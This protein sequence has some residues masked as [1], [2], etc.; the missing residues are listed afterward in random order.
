MLQKNLSESKQKVA[1][2][3]EFL[4][5]KDRRIANLE[6]QIKALDRKYKDEL[7]HK[8]FNITKLE[9]EL[10]ERCGELASL[11]MT[12]LTTRTSHNLN[13]SRETSHNLVKH[14]RDPQASNYL[15]DRSRYTPDAG[16][17]RSRESSFSSSQGDSHETFEDL[18]SS[19][20]TK[21]H[22]PVPPL[23]TSLSSKKNPLRRS[24]ASKVLTEVK[25]RPAS[26]RKLVLENTS[27]DQHN[28]FPDQTEILK[29]V[30]QQKETMDLRHGRGM[31]VPPIKPL[32][33]DSSGAGAQPIKK[34]SPRSA[35]S[36][37]FSKRVRQKA[38][39]KH[40]KNSSP[41]V[42]ILAVDQVNNKDLRKAQEFG[43]DTFK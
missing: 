35:N 42:E 18:E 15:P 17:N 25:N 5:K 9:T 11:R 21:Q 34:L 43:H 20:Y 7:R 30:A 28:V 19:P 4:H 12:V 36:A 10:Q 14:I 33:K 16:L 27:L 26:G 22:I 31:V 1:E 3:E 39:E 2:Q 41:E 23:S 40:D 13:G 37:A 8:Q 29:I 6:Q 24:S 32:T 38:K